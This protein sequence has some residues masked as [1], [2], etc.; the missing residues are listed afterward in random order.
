MLV[1]HDAVEAYLV[2]QGVLVVVF[3]IEHV[4]LFRI[5]VGVW[6]PQPARVILRQLAVAHVALGL[7]GKPVDLYFFFGA[8]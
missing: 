5:E 8:G 6:K 7:F 2:G 3:V 1:S 4:S